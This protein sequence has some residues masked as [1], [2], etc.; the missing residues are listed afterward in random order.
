LVNSS[1]ESLFFGLE[2]SISHAGISDHSLKRLLSL[3][4]FLVLKCP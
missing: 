3:R 1:W 4:L 2:A